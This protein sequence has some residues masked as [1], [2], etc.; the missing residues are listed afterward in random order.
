MNELTLFSFS[1]NSEYSLENCK[2]LSD[3]H[4]QTEIVHN[5]RQ[6]AICIVL[7]DPMKLLVDTLLKGFT[8]SLHKLHEYP[9]AFYIFYFKGTPSPEKNKPF[10]AL[11]D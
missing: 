11:Q 8:C 2:I 9:V 3:S 5:I 7:D 4:M 1:I 10:S 6:Y